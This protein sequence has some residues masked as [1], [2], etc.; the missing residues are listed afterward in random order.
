MTHGSYFQNY[1]VALCAALNDDEF[2]AFADAVLA[3]LQRD[4]ARAADAAYLA[5]LVEQLGASHAQR[6]P[7]GRSASVATLRT[8]VKTFLAWAQL[9]N[10]TKVFPAFPNRDQAER[11]DIFPG[12]MDALYRAD[13]TNILP[14]AKHYLDRIGTTYGA[15]TKV[16]PADATAQYAALE[17]AL[18][19]RTT[20]RAVRQ[21]GSAAVDADE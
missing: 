15:Q 13:H 3:N 11:I 18:T 21:E 10:T 2:R 1:F 19:G 6:G 4:P 20:A 14:R 8:A 9:T 5:P 16:T 17:S 7:Q 12:G